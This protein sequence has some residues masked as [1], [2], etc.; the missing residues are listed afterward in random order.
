MRLYLIL[1]EADQAE[2][3]VMRREVEGLEVLSHRLAQQDQPADEPES[4]E[5][6]RRPLDLAA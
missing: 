3:E 1:D 6:R 2:R 4:L 5:A